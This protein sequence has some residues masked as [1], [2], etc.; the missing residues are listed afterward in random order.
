MSQQPP[1]VIGRDLGGYRIEAVLGRGGM[2]VVYRATDVRLGRKVALKVLPPEFGNDETFRARFLRESRAA[3]AIDH[4][5]VIPVYEAGDVGG[6]LY[7]AMRYVDGIDLEGMLEAEGSLAPERALALVAQLAAALD[8]A[9]EGG[10]V[11]RDVKP[12]NAL[13]AKGDHVYLCDF[14]L[15]TGAADDVKLTASGEVAGTAL[16]MAPETLR[17]GR[18]DA[19][20]DLYSLG[21]VL[22]E[23]LVGEP[24]FTGR[25]PAA[26]IFARLEESPPRV[27]ERR[28]GLPH[29]LDSVLARALDKLPEH[30]YASGAELVAAVRAAL[31]GRAPARPRRRLADAAID[32]EHGSLTG[33][34]TLDGA[35]DAIAAGAGAVWVTDRDR[36]VVSRVDTDTR[37]IRQTIPVGHAP[38]AIAV[39]PHGVWVANSQ[40]GTVSVISPRT[41]QVAQ[42]ISVG[43]QVDGLGAAGGAV[44]VASP[45]DY[46]VVR[47]DP[48]TG[49]REAKVILDRQPAKLA[50]GDGVVWASSPSTG[51]VTKISASTAKAS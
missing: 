24:P 39:E 46:A 29:A 38:S 26:V 28:G 14:G 9:H 45:L 16:Y 49:R 23:C 30:R 11:H 12:S 27:S 5:G 2:G 44:W 17:T 6:Q 4:P 1:E 13:V 50:C 25:T 8:A 48:D 42:R 51:T 35:P 33:Q 19:R 36:N 22:F 3:A 18:A 43:R 15:T 20:S 41:S 31:A 21:C 40:D 7:I 34:V 47:L 32:P 10:L 37:T